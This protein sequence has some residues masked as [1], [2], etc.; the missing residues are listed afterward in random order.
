V[1]ASARN[2][3]SWL[4]QNY[5]KLILVVILIG[6]LLSAF[7]LFMEIGQKRKEL[8]EA[9]WEKMTVEP[10]QVE[11]IKPLLVQFDQMKS[12][13][14]SPFQSG[15]FSN[16]MVVSELR[17]SCVECLKPI[18]YDATVCAF[19]QAKQPAGISPDEMDSDG[20]GIPDKF[21]RESGL[22][23]LDAND[24]VVD[25]DSDGFS[26]KEEWRSGTKL[27]DANDYP[28][29][30]AK[31]RFVRAV[32]NP[33]KLRFQG[34]ARVSNGMIY[35]LNLRS[36]E[37]TYFVRIGDELEGFKVLDCDT[38]AA[39]GPTIILKQGD[40]RISLVKGKTREGFEMVAELVFLIDQSK[41]RVRL[42]DVI[43]LKEREYKVIDIR[44]DGVLIRDEKT[45]KTTQV[46][47]LSASEKIALESGL[48]N[49]TQLGPTT[50]GVT[51]PLR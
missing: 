42:G 30:V 32:D 14:N 41:M 44:R 3:S 8:A 50:P 43:K 17:V 48:S 36:L 22:N 21:E 11:P 31:L 12:A 6:L 47:P 15:Q 23:P 24:A 45:R 20:D 25:T 9:A 27:N 40:K 51:R 28:S 16:R 18:P 7:F 34:E 10:K 37:R 49:P 4:S 1:S 2:R 46:G 13:L 39:A 26:N 35:Q 5:D 29:P 38:N 19:C 33:F